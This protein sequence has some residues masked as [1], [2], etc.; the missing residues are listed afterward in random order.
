MA[1]GRLTAAIPVACVPTGM[2]I[3]V[4]QR[5]STA[6]I[7][8][9]TISF[10]LPFLVLY[11]RE[12]R[13]IGLLIL[14]SESFFFDRLKTSMRLSLRGRLRLSMTFPSLPAPRR[15]VYLFLM[16]MVSAIP[17]WLV[18][19]NSTFVSSQNPEY[20]HTV[21]PTFAISSFTYAAILDDELDGGAFDTLKI[22]LTGDPSYQKKDRFLVCK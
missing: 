3:Y 16:M 7:H 4:V 22:D 17:F 19:S 5:R 18:I 1:C 21:F 9:S 8:F 20:E 14:F 6:V 2:L 15:L 11:L 13:L 10:N 12:S